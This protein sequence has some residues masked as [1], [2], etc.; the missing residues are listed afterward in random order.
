LGRRFR[1]TAT[2]E[3]APSKQKARLCG[4]FPKRLKGL[5]PS[6]FC[7]AITPIAVL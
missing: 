1:E 3:A 4:P 7:M 5:E 6:T 2:A